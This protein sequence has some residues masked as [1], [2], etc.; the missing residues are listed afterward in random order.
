MSML[1]QKQNPPLLLGKN[2]TQAIQI[3]QKEYQTAS[4]NEFSMEEHFPE[5]RADAEGDMRNT[6]RGG[7]NVSVR[8]GQMDSFG[9]YPVSQ[10]EHV[11]RTLHSLPEPQGIDEHVETEAEPPTAAGQESNTSDSNQPEGI[12]NTNNANVVQSSES[13]QPEGISST[14]KANVVQSSESNQPE[15]NIS[16]TNDANVVPLSSQA[17]K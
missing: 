11:A 16:N 5:D 9:V 3:N 6:G 1:K 4:S 10:I 14:N 8:H 15:G 7:Y 17:V 2:Q 13:S 12:S